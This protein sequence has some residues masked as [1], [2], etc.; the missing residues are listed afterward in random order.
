[1]NERIRDLVK[2][3]GGSI[4]T[5]NLMSNPVQSI[6]T[7]ELWD[8]RIEKFAGLLIKECAHIAKVNQAQNMN[9]DIGEILIEH[10]GV[11]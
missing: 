5:R 4:S 2:K 10:F 9:W 6:E 8:D 3:A 11:E 1:M 7:V